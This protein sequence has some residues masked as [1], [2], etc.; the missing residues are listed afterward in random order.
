MAK[1]HN[2]AEQKEAGMTLPETTLISEQIEDLLIKSRI[3]MLLTPNA[4][5]FWQPGMSTYL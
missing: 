5:F 1:A 3:K 4:A 2:T